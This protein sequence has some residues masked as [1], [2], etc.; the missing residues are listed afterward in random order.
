MLQIPTLSHG[1]HM[2][3]EA[4]PKYSDSVNYNHV[5]LMLILIRTGPFYCGANTAF[6]V[7]EGHYRVSS[8]FVALSVVKCT[9]TCT[10]IFYI[11]HRELSRVN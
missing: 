2:V 7:T 3:V 5:C 4:E 9:F 8:E 1:Y 10:C 11:S 6:D